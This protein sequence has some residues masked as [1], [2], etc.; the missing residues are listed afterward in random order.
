M[1]NIEVAIAGVKIASKILNIPEPT[2]YFISQHQLPNPEISG[3]FRFE[4]YE[5]IFNEEWVL[6]SE[7]IEIV[8]NC[9]HETRHAYQAYSVKNKINESIEVLSKWEEEINNYIIPTDANNEKSDV[10]YLKQDIEVDAIRFTY[11][12][13]KELFQ[14]EIVIPNILKHLVFN[15]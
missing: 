4:E 10:D 13:I 6:K 8:I 3:I 2:V 14:V 9:F 7:W 12:K 15:E 1:N 5:I 11:H